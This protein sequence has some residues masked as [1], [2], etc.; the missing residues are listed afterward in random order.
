MRF[1]NETAPYWGAAIP[2]IIGH[3]DE[4]LTVR[5]VKIFTDGAC[6]VDFLA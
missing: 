5:S 6:L 4:R 3:A 1:F 2:K